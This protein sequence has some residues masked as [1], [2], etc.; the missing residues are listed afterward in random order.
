ML[1]RDPDNVSALVLLGQAA[2]AM[3]WPETA[4]YA[5]ETA[6]GLEP[7]RPDIVLAL[8]QALLAAGRTAEA[9]VT[10]KEALRLQSRRILCTVKRPWLTRWRMAS[11]SPAARHAVRLARQR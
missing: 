1:R 3:H 7:D 11:G 9:V 5:Y 8:G 4:V 10:A 6:R 2:L